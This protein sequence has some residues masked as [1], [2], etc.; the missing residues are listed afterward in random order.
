MNT[1][2]GRKNG[3]AICICCRINV[4]GQNDFHAG[5]II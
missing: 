2:I 1:Y 4:I 3:E 5:H